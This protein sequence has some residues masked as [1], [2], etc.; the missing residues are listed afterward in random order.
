VS[1]QTST[2]SD[3][4]GTEQNADELE[5]V[6]TLDELVF[7]QEDQLQSHRSTCQIWFF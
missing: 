4:S 6:M 2:D 5:I 1:I 7:S 3:T